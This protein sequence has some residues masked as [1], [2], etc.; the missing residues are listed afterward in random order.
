MGEQQKNILLVE[1]HEILGET[2]VSAF[3]RKGIVLTWLQTFKDAKQAIARLPQEPFDPIILDANLTE[4]ESDGWEGEALLNDIR[5]IAPETF[6]IG[7][8]AGREFPGEPDFFISKRS[9]SAMED[10]LK[11]VQARIR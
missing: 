11:A 4:G 3:R 5:G 8:S 2:V 6:I 1:D 10:L 9:P 7:F